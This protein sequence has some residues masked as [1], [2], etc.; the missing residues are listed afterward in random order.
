MLSLSRLFLSAE[1]Q[2]FKQ[3]GDRTAGL[4]LPVFSTSPRSSLFFA[5]SST[6]A[7]LLRFARSLASFVSAASIPYR[8][9]LARLCQPCRLPA[10]R[11]FSSPPPFP[12]LSPRPHRSTTSFRRRSSIARRGNASRMSR[13]ATSAR[14]SPPRDSGT[15][16]SFRTMRL[17]TTG[18]RDGRSSRRGRR[19][20]S[21]QVSTT[22]SACDPPLRNGR[23]RIDFPFSF[24]RNETAGTNFVRSSVSGVSGPR[25]DSPHTRRTRRAASSRSRPFRPSTRST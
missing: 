8:P 20:P 21:S 1:A 16:K 13:T 23:T 12:S 19:L 3:V 15:A 2:Q 22:S 18:R 25:S 11:G 14:G 17:H 9:R 4:E 7:P 24:S 6:P 5:A 10:G